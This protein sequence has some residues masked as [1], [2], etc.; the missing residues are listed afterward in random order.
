MNK[1]HNPG[2]LPCSSNSIREYD[3]TMLQFHRL[4]QS[5]VSATP[6]TFDLVSS[7]SDAATTEATEVHPPSETEYDVDV[8]T[9]FI[10]K[11]CGCTKANGKP[12]S[13]LLSTEHYIDHRAQTSLLNRQQLDL[14]LL[15]S[16]MTI[17][18]Y[19]DS[20]VNGR[21]KPANRR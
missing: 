16:I 9:T 1:C 17:G 15:G 21:H 19:S 5:P 11:T 20:I 12:C 6:S 3:P 13:T 14:V 7:T 18:L 4:S 10:Q 8:C 2:Q